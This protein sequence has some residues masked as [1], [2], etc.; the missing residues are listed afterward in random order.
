MVVAHTRT[1]VLTHSHTTL[2][3][4]RDVCF[5]CDCCLSRNVLLRTVHNGG[6]AQDKDGVEIENK[7][8]LPV[9]QKLY[10]RGD[11]RA[12]ARATQKIRSEMDKEM[13]ER[14]YVRKHVPLFDK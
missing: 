9:R 13:L 12:V 3:N 1:H 7:P 5:R 6:V 4:D 10:F 14:K 11:D 8:I 2:H